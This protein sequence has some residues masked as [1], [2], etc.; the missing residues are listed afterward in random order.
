MIRINSVNQ[1]VTLKGVFGGHK[2][3]LRRTGQS[4]AFYPFQSVPG[5]PESESG[6]HSWTLNSE[7]GKAPKLG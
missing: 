1:L 5:T 7:Q 3:F 4:D 2:D 6:L